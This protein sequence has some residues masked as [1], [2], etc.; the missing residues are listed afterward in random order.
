MAEMSATPEKRERGTSRM[1]VVTPQRIV[2][3]V[4]ANFPRWLGPDD[5]VVINDTRV[6]PARLFA[7][8]RPGMTRRIEILLTPAVET[9]AAQVADATPARGGSKGATVPA[10]GKAAPPAPK[11]KSGRK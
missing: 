10:K 6:I 5:V 4:F 7:R 8:P 1:M 3:D 2:H 9:K 11:K